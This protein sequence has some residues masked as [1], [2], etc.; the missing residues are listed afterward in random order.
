MTC[1]PPTCQCPTC[2]Q[3][4]PDDAIRIDFSAGIVVGNGRFVA[5]PRREM[6]VLAVLWERRGRMVTKDQIF[7]A[8]YADND[9]VEFADV[10]ESHMSKMRKKVKPLGLVIRSERFRGYQL[11]TGSMR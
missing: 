5:L 7:R 6:D 2:G 8:V 10:V 3:A 11:L 1:Q 4:L 9:G